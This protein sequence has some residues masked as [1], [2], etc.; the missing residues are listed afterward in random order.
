M[1]RTVIKTTAVAATLAG[2][3]LLAT[4]AFA[5]VQNAGSASHNTVNIQVIGGYG[6]TCVSSAVGG[7]SG[8]NCSRNTVTNFDDFSFIGRR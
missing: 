3:T 6:V 5:G 1:I 7:A 4:P 2:G 8:Q